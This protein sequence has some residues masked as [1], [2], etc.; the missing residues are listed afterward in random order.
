MAKKTKES[1]L[2][3]FFN[4]FDIPAYP[5]TAVP[6]NATYPY[7]T[8][9]VYIG[10]FGEG[11][12]ACTVNLW[13]YTMSEAKPNQKADEIGKAVGLGGIRL[14]CDDGMIWVKR[15]TPFCQSLTDPTD[16]TIKRRYINLDIE[17]ITL[18]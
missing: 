13:Y 4:S 10:A 7:M 11:E 1:A 6:D 14:L 2:Y 5:V 18:A 3:D 9:E 12:T 15:G 17:Y 16:K 8:Y